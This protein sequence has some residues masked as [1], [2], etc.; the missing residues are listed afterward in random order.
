MLCPGSAFSFVGL[1]IPFLS[2][3]HMSDA[4]TK[5]IRV[6]VVSKYIPEGSDVDHPLYFFA[7]HITISNEGEKPVKLE[8]RYWHITDA[9]GQVEEVRGPGVV[10]HQP[11]LNPGE[12]FRYTSF[13]PLRTEFGIMKGT[14]RM[15]YDNGDSFNVK[16]AP[17]NLVTPQSVN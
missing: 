16:I 2:L 9:T 13:C 5:G 4:I 10:G 15:Y 11:R 8:S 12:S 6:S 14:Y 3:H 17:F 7:Y 1:C